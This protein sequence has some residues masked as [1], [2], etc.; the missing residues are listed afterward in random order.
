M[1]ALI[2]DNDEDRQSVAQ[3]LQDAGFRVIQALK[4]SEGLKSALDDT[5]RIVIVSE[6]MPPVEEVEL[7]PVL[8]RLTDSPIITV[9]SG[10]EMAMV[11][12]L[13]QG[14][15]VYL[16]RPVNI[17]ELMAR[18]RALLRRYGAARGLNGEPMLQC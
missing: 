8:R 7:L 18:I 13:L 6:D 17:R 5:P 14:A 15:D 4:S 9:G 16:T 1:T 2:I 3:A 10:G 11:Q 12:A